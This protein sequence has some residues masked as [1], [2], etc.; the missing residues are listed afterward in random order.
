VPVETEVGDRRTVLESCP[1]DVAHEDRSEIGALLVM[2]LPW[3]ASS[4]AISAGAALLPSP[5]WAILALGGFAG[6]VVALARAAPATTVLLAPL[7]VLDL[8]EFV[9]GVIIEIGAAMAE[10]GATGAPSGAFAH[11]LLLK[12]ALLTAS[13]W[14]IEQSWRSVRPR[15]ESIAAGWRARA[16]PLGYALLLLLTLA[17][18]VLALLAARHGVP[19]I[20]HFD[21]FTY[22]G[23]LDGTPYRSIMMNRPVIAPLIGVLIALPERRRA[24]MSLLGWLLLLSILFGEKFASLLLILGGAAIAPLLAGLARRNALP[25]R[26]ILGGTAALAALTLPVIML[27]YGALDSRDRAWARFSERATVQGQ[28]WYLA[29]RAG[30]PASVDSPALRADLVS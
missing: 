7:L 13:A 28:L 11:L 21:R 26:L 22:L 10:T 19:L 9:S 15:F 18:I 25:L 17:S 23:R 27:T 29:D 4:A 3:L 12:I 8:S 20:G 30:P 24:G 2:A 5:G 6:F 16:S 14:P 1:P